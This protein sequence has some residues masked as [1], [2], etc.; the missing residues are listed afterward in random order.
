MLEEKG[1]GRMDGKVH[2]HSGSGE[3]G[4]VPEL[5][6][7]DDSLIGEVIEIF[8]ENVEPSFSRCREGINKVSASRLWG[9]PTNLGLD[10]LMRKT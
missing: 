5:D 3:A 1:V 7:G 6:A 4:F 10:S 8:T 9:E 2:C